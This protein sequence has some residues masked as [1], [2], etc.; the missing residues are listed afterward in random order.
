MVNVASASYA[1]FGYMKDDEANRLAAFIQMYDD[2]IAIL[3]RLLKW[4]RADDL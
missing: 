4:W 3:I 2:T 1:R